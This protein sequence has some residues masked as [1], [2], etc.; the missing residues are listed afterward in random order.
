MLPRAPVSEVTVDSIQ[1]FTA[2]HGSSDQA[3]LCQWV[4]E[5]CWSPLLLL[6][7]RCWELTP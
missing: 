3:F 1:S 7:P 2:A 6:L 5:S 4:Q